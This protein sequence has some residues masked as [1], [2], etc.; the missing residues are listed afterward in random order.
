MAWVG[1][2]GMAVA[3][4]LSSAMSHAA[5]AEGQV[6]L[7]C[8]GTLLEARGQAE[9]RRTTARLRA[10]LS[11][12]AEAGTSGEALERL[13]QRLAGVRSAMQ[14]LAAQQLRVSSPS[15]WV[16]PREKEQEAIVQANLQVSASLPPAT[17]QS[18]IRTVGTLPGV[19]LAPVETEADPG[20]NAR[21][22]QEL[23]EESYRDALNQ[24]KT[25]AFLIHRSV[26]TPV[27][28]QLETDD[29]AVPVLRSM[30]AGA[31]PPFN[32]NELNNPSNRI[33]MRVRFCV[34]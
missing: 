25:L 29:M 31:T 26:L 34:S 18:L 6:Q 24:A 3:G 19:R 33:T 11:L 1:M 22:R 32:P 4:M 20:D 10:T 21:V 30:A 9:Q 15:T 2:A 27:E 7:Q 23:L 28:I 17:L 16:R 12:D 5:M 8:A 14:A 13:Q